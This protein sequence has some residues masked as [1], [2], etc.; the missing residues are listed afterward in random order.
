MAELQP[1]SNTIRRDAI[2]H[3]GH[4]TFGPSSSVSQIP[5]ELN[6]DSITPATIVVGADAN[7]I[8]SDATANPLSA[9]AVTESVATASVSSIPRSRITLPDDSQR[10]AAPSARH[11]SGAR[12]R[13]TTVESNARD[14][15]RDHRHPGIR[16][17]SPLPGDTPE[18]VDEPMRMEHLRILVSRTDA[19]ET[20]QVDN[21]R[22]Q[23]SLQSQVRIM[24]VGVEDICDELVERHA[25][26]V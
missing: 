25:K 13:S 21:V 17:R 22:E 10:P 4:G 8:E 18:P 1:T 7:V 2:S 11:G 3:R 23:R 16:G 14:G 12:F 9:A 26:A 24:G 6:V 15:E 5:S 20:A 19:L